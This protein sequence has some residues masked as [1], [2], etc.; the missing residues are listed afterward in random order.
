VGIGLYVHARNSEVAIESIAVLPF[1]NK[2]GDPDT[3]YL[4]D[5]LSESLIYRLSQLP[6]LRVSPTSSVF[7]Y[8]NKEIDPNKVRES[9]DS[10]LSAS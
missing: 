2:S 10:V 4:S 1:Q 5:G 7:R 3:E 8:K 9:W 6:K